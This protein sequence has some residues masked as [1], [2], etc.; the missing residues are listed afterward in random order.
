MWQREEKEKQVVTIE[1]WYDRQIRLWTILK[2]D[3]NDNQI[4]H[5]E[6]EPRIADL[7]I[8]LA[9]MAKDYPRAR[10]VKF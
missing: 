8:T 4:D 2:K 7:K 5:A 9:E 3:G 6:Y 1:Y 10:F